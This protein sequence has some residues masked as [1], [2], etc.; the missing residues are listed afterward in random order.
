MLCPLWHLP[1]VDSSGPMNVKATVVHWSECILFHS[2]S[3]QLLPVIWRCR[4]SFA[5]NFCEWLHQ[6]PFL[7]ACKVS[8]DIRAVAWQECLSLLLYSSST[9]RQ[10]DSPQNRPQI[11][12]AAQF[13]AV[14]VGCCEFISFL[15]PSLSFPS[16]ASLFNPLHRCSFLSESVFFSLAPGVC[17]FFFHLRTCQ[18]LLSFHTGARSWCLP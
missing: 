4:V 8:L 16:L 5:V 3:L 13:A 18:R 15:S 11:T 12:A 7:C 10:L 2:F 14:A 6:A 1:A 9:R 17:H